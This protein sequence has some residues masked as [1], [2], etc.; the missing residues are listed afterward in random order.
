MLRMDLQTD[1]VN[2]RK[3]FSVKKLKRKTDGQT[4]IHTE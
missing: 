1:I 4:E 2:Y 3:S